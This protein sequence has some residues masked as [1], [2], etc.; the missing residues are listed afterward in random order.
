VS[1]AALKAFDALPLKERLFVRG[2]LFTAPLLEVS[3]RVPSG[4][5]VDV[6]CGHGL[7]VSL[8]ASGRPER[9]VVGIDPDGRKI[10]WAK[11][12]VGALPNVSLEVGTVEG[13]AARA[14]GTFDAV[15][16][17]DVLYLL[18]RAEWR[19]FLTAAHALLKPGGVLLLKEAEADRGWR[20]IKC[21]AQERLMV[22]LLRRTKSSGGLGFVPRAQMELELT[23]AGFELDEII[24]L[25]RG[26]TTPHVLFAARRS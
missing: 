10:D 19:S 26:Y 12:S 17:C 1:T 4:R 11:A 5:I 24:G 6:G 22:Q 20:Y 15:V 13:L 7:M 3:Q 9:T 23:H 14:A 8:L 18:P 16:V 25:A 21:L 2:R